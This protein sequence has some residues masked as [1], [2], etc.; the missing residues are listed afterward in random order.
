MFHTWTRGNPKQLKTMNELTRI[1]NEN[2]SDYKISRAPE[3]LERFPEGFFVIGKPCPIDWFTVETPIAYG[4]HTFMTEFTVGVLAS[5]STESV[6][7]L[8]SHFTQ[9]GSIH[10]YEE[11]PV[12]FHSSAHEENPPLLFIVHYQNHGQLHP[13]NS[14]LIHTLPGLTLFDRPKLLDPSWGPAIHRAANAMLSEI[15]IE[16]TVNPD[17]SYST[18]ISLVMDKAMKVVKGHFDEHA[19]NEFLNE[20]FTFTKSQTEV[21][22]EN[23][24]FVPGFYTELVKIIFE[25]LR[26]MGEANFTTTLLDSLD[27][28]SFQETVLQLGV[29]H[30]GAFGRGLANLLPEDIDVTMQNLRFHIDTSASRKKRIGES[31]RQQDHKATQVQA[32]YDSLLPL[33]DRIFV[34]TTLSQPSSLA[35][36][37]HCPALPGVHVP[38]GLTHAYLIF[39]EI[40]KE[41]LYYC[42]K[43]KEQKIS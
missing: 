33:R 43:L 34:Q 37:R 14:R 32:L 18:N 21:L 1:H 12:W 19:T 26:L 41:T 13:S 25:K 31:V 24:S 20:N 39:S 7:L 5:P 27:W 42:A 8:P 40:A 4:P 16:K 30:N 17:F 2:I 9:L 22:E 28:D 35:S 10:R 6:D 38:D 36:Q 29:G 11:V 15:S 23:H 3:L